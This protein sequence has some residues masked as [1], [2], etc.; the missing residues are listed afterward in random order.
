VPEDGTPDDR[1]TAPASPQPPGPRVP[2]GV[3]WRARPLPA[4]DVQYRVATIGRLPSNDVVVDDLA[5]HRRHAELLRLPDGRFEIVDLGGPNGTYVNGV[6]IDRKTL[7]E[8]DI[9]TI[10][11]TT[12]RLTGGQ[13]LEYAGEGGAS[14]PPGT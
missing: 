8:Q 7:T 13:L 4:A 9:V 3:G 2:R 12:L 10:G 14:S 6:R 5:A 11:H 1:A